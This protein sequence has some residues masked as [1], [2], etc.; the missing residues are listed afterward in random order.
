LAGPS[1]CEHGSADAEN[2]DKYKS[3]AQIDALNYNTSSVNV[4][5][6]QQKEILFSYRLVYSSSCKVP[7]SF[8]RI[9]RIDFIR[10]FE[11]ASGGGGF[12]DV[13]DHREFQ[14]AT[15]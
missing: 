7:S 6:L 15:R 8:Q 13:R 11:V 14:S 3:L 4:F 2:N 9:A 1:V 12:G 10:Y 5:Y